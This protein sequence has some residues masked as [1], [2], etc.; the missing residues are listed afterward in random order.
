MDSVHSARLARIKRPV[1]RPRRVC[2]PILLDALDALEERTLFSVAPIKNINPV[3]LGPAEITG[4]AGEDSTYCRRTQGVA[5]GY[6][7]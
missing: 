1:E 3:N 6:S 7:V 5:W 4:V 2:T